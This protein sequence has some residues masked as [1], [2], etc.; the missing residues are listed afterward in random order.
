MTTTPLG[1]EADPWQVD[2]DTVTRTLTIERG[3]VILVAQQDYSGRVLD[4]KLIIDEPWLDLDGAEDLAKRLPAIVEQLR[5]L[6]DL[7]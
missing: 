7:R 1:A 5:G 4:A 2:G 3:N 6:V